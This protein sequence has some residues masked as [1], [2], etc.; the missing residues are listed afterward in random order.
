[1]DGCLHWLGLDG[2]PR[3][4]LRAHSKAV[5]VL[6]CGAERVVSGGYDTILKVHRAVDFF[7]ET[8]VCI[9]DGSITTVVLDKVWREGGR[10]GGRREGVSEGG[11]ERERGSEEGGGR[12]GGIE[13]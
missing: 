12:E 9:H 4:C 1:M 3:H 10:E 6:R 5:S 8:A 11:R 2:Q 7:C 13:E